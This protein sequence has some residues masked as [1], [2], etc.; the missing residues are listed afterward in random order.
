MRV[1]VREILRVGALMTLASVV[2]ACAVEEFDAAPTTPIVA[3]TCEQDVDCVSES[4]SG[5]CGPG[6]CVAATGDILAAF[7]E[8]APPAAAVFGAGDSFLIPLEDLEHGRVNED[9]ILP[10]YAEITGKLTTPIDLLGNPPTESCEQAYDSATQTLRVHV[11]LSR[12]EAVQGL[13][14]LEVAANAELDSVT[15]AG[16]S[17]STFRLVVTMSMRRFCR[18]ATRTFHRSSGQGRSLR[19]T[20]PNASSTWIRSRNCQGS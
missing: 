19:P 12:S 2:E 9:L 1:A 6:I 4:G 14:S 13:P 17:R 10:A 5:T 20:S 11:K 8:V 3:N 15:M 7:V 18:D 16:H